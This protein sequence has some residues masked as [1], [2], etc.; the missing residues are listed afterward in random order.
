[1]AITICLDLERTHFVHLTISKLS[2][3]LQ[4]WDGWITN[5]S[6]GEVMMD[7][8]ICDKNNRPLT[9]IFTKETI[10]LLKFALI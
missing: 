2:K 5:P 1:M 10:N 9:H 7:M 6:F 8:L 4:F 3:W